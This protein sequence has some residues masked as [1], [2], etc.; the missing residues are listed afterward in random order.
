MQA[1]FT[2]ALFAAAWGFRQ[3]QRFRLTHLPPEGMI[4]LWEQ[5]CGAIADQQPSASLIALMDRTVGSETWLGALPAV[6]GLGNDA[7]ADLMT[8]WSELGASQGAIAA[9]KLLRKVQVARSEAEVILTPVNNL[10]IA[11]SSEVQTFEQARRSYLIC[12]PEADLSL[13][14][15]LHQAEQPAIAAALLGTL[16]GLH[17]PRTSLPLSWF[18]IPE[19]ERLEAA[20]RHLQRFWAGYLNP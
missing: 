6:L 10:E 18:L 9:L 15:C 14:H 11:P 12:R 17:L 4:R 13:R 7:F 2:G 1:Q 19:A 3:G 16:L 5:M 8:T 20:T